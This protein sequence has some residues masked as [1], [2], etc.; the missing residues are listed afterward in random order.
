[1]ERNDEWMDMIPL[2]DP[3]HKENDIIFSNICLSDARIGWNDEFPL[4]IS[5]CKNIGRYYDLCNKFN[6]FKANFRENA[7]QKDYKS[8]NIKR[9]RQSVVQISSILSNLSSIVATPTKIKIG[10]E[11]LSLQSPKANKEKPTWK[12]LA[13]ALDEWELLL[14]ITEDVDCPIDIGKNTPFRNGDPMLSMFSPGDIRMTPIKRKSSSRLSVS[15]LSKSSCPG[16]SI[17][18]TEY[19]ESRS[20]PPKR[21][22]RRSNEFDSTSSIPISNSPLPFAN[23]PREFN[24]QQMN[25]DTD[26]KLQTVGS[27]LNL[28]R[29]LSSTTGL[30]SA[31]SL[32]SPAQTM[33]P[34]MNSNISTPTSRVALTTNSAS[35]P[36]SNPK[37]SPRIQSQ[38]KVGLK[39]TPQKNL[40]NDFTRP[41]PGKEQSF[42]PTKSLSHSSHHNTPSKSPTQSLKSMNSPKTHSASKNVSTSPS[43]P[44][45]NYGNSPVPDRLERS[46]LFS[47]NRSLPLGSERIVP[48]KSVLLNLNAHKTVMSLPYRR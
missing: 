41:S 43:P 18:A 2:C 42:T 9:R 17:T 35:S 6:L 29:P 33:S 12:S 36:A 14:N 32:R 8:L 10:N 37:L 39:T 11:L 30:S 47:T 27:S 21:S 26:T 38:M 16:T 23:N 15:P 22:S 31:K 40:R 48:S 24:K 7:G 28:S 20:P 1:M 19:Q 44:R 45:N 25:I 4:K 13:T 3:S 46:S 34:R 5:P